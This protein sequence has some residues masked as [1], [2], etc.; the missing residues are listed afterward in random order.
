[1]LFCGTLV[2]IVI[3]CSCQSDQQITYARYYLSGKN[4]YIKHCQN[5]HG[6]KGEGLGGLVP[7]LTDSVY[8][9]N[10]YVK[11]PCIIKNGLKGEIAINGKS[12]K[13]EMPANMQLANIEIAEIATYL[14]NSFGNKLGVY[15]VIQVDSNMK[16]CR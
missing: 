15:S 2:W 10:R 11:I 1:M 14:T 12:F 6:V 9:K 7:P 5:C 16:D 3:S 8:I 13:E 4:L